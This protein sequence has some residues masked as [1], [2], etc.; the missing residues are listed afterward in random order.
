MKHRSRRW[1]SFASIVKRIRRRYRRKR[2]GKR[3]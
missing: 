3:V 1:R 2:M